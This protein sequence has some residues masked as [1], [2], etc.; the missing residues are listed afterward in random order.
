M[1][2]KYDYADKSKQ[3]NKKKTKEKQK[4]NSTVGT[5]RN[6]SAKLEPD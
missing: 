3:R 6:R 1:K 4:N 5:Q 2:P